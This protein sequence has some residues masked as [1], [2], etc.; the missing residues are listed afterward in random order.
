MKKG[1]V[2]AII[3]ARAGSKGITNKNTSLLDGKPLISYSVELTRNCVVLNDV[4]VTSDDK[5][6]LEIS[7]KILE[8]IF[9]RG[10]IFTEKV[11]I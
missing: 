7:K 11:I 1:K 5:T 8:Q 4:I 3:P 6:V 2:L 10:K 9:H